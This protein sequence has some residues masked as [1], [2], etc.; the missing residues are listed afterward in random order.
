MVVRHGCQIPD[1]ANSTIFKRAFDLLHRR[2][3]H[4]EWTAKTPYWC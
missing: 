1:A 2:H 4:N 3:P